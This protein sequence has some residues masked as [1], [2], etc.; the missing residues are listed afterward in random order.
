MKKIPITDKKVV[1]QL[2][3]IATDL[4]NLEKGSL[5]FL[6]RRQ[7][8]QLPRM[9]VSNIC[10]V[11]RGI[12]YNTIAEVLKRDRT[13]IYHYESQHKILYQTWSKYRDIFNKIY[14]AFSDRKEKHLSQEQ[15]VQILKESGVKNVQAPKVFIDITVGDSATRIESDYRNFTECVE[16]IKFALKD[17]VYNIHIEL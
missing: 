1:K 16:L 13:S 6:S 15:L 12:H 2:C 4:Y 10:R 14:N 7:D 11:D 17:Y 9:A 3:N 8:L 5:S